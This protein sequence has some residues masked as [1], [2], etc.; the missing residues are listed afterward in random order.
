[1]KFQGNTDIN[2]FQQY[3]HAVKE[4][5]S[6][7]FHKNTKNRLNPSFGGSFVVLLDG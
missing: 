4:E 3:G 6:T 1:M 5:R 2:K 7:K